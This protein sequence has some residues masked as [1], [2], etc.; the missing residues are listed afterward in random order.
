MAVASLAATLTGMLE[1]ERVFE[2]LPLLEDLIGDWREDVHRLEDCHPARGVSRGLGAR[3][4][5]T[6]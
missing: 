4:I 3:S 5:L 1:A 2:M 6:R